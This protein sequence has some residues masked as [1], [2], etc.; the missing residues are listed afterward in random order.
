[1]PIK[2]LEAALTS[3]TAGK[4]RRAPTV[5]QA[6]VARNPPDDPNGKAGVAPE[7][8]GQRALGDPADASH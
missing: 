1:V 7:R 8:T 2:G 4:L 6:K 5:E 3:T